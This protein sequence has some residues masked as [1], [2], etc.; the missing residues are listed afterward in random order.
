MPA[1]SCTATLFSLLEATEEEGQI[2]VAKKTP[3]NVYE[4]FDCSKHVTFSYCSASGSTDADND[5]DDTNVSS[6]SAVRLPTSSIALP[7][8]ASFLVCVT[9]KHKKGFRVPL[10]PAGQ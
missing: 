9:H 4:T 3:R 7:R 2:A 8:C 6:V 5:N 10:A 1:P